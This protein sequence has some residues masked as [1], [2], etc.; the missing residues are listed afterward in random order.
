LIDNQIGGTDWQFEFDNAVR[1]FGC[2]HWRAKKITLSRK[3]VQ[4]NDEARVRNTILHEIAHALCGARVGHGR[5]W[6]QM[7][8]AIGCDGNRLYSM[9]VVETPKRK[10]QGTCPSCARVIQAH[11]RN[12]IACGRCCNNYNGGRFTEKYLII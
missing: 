10:Y 4:L 8:K 9:A 6:V 5:Q 1:R 12:K 11:R 2:C 3:L 7:A